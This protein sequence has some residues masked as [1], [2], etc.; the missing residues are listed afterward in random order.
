MFLLKTLLLIN[1]KKINI[2]GVMLFIS[3]PSR[4]AQRK[5]IFSGLV[6]LL[7]QGF[8]WLFNLVILLRKILTFFMS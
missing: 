4:L 5:K 7:H 3:R 1:V 2:V 8:I 6:E